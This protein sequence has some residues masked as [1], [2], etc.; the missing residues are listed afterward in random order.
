MFFLSCTA[1]TD[2]NARGKTNSK[3][4]VILTFTIN[5]KYFYLIQSN[6]RKV[7]LVAVLNTVLLSR[8]I[9]QIISN[10]N[11]IIPTARP[12]IKRSHIPQNNFFYKR[13]RGYTW[14]RDLS[15]LEN[16]LGLE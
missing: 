2:F 11:I 15:L 13:T 6:Y 9:F 7:F 3:L 4:S 16:K 1:N 12:D 10:I 8:E 14:Y 5:F